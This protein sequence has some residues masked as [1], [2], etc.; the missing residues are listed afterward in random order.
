MW[1]FDHSL[2]HSIFI[3]ILSPFHCLFTI[4]S[5]YIVIYCYYW[6]TFTGL[7]LLLYTGA[8]RHIFLH[9]PSSFYTQALDERHLSIIKFKLE[10]LLVPR[11]HKVEVLSAK[12]PEEGKDKKREED[13]ARGSRSSTRSPRHPPRAGKKQQSSN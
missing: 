6:N 10:P 12:S 7:V 13:T 2:D 9:L 3:H 8:Q 4:F 11:F 1:G 5:P